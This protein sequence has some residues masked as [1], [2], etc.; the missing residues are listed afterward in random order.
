MGGSRSQVR[1]HDGRIWRDAEMQY[2]Y[3]ADCALAKTW[4]VTGWKAEIAANV[5]GPQFLPEGRGREKSP[6]YVLWDTRIAKSWNRFE[7]SLVAR[8][9]FDWTQSDNPYLREL[10]TGRLEPDAALAYGPLLGRV[11]YLGM[12]YSM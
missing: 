6:P 8:N 2:T 9:L 5:Y 7:L 3:S 4:R 11:V 12:A 10:D 1:Y